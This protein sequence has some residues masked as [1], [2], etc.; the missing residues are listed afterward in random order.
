MGEQR[1]LMRS[2]WVQYAGDT[3]RAVHEYAA[4]EDAGRVPRRSNSSGMSS[5]DYAR[6]LLADGLKK[7]WLTPTAS[8]RVSGRGERAGD[9]RQESHVELGA[10]LGRSVKPVATVGISG[11]Y[12]SA[13]KGTFPRDAF[14]TPWNAAERFC[15]AQA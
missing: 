14:S 12:E 10:S 15:N 9:S 13:Q 7:G 6:R 5:L 2:L 1:D 11:G 4:A 3:D 8:P